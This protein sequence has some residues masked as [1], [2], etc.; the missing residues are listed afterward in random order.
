LFDA[1]RFNFRS[2][3]KTA[4]DIGTIVHKRLADFL[5]TGKYDPPINPKAL[6]GYKKGVEWLKDHHC[7][8]EFIETMGYSRRYEF[9][10]TIDYVGYIEDHPCIL[11]FK[12]SKDIY[13]EYEWQIAAYEQIRYEMDGTRRDGWVLRVGKEDGDFED[14]HIDQPTLSGHLNAFVGLVPIWHRLRDAD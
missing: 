8:V 4:T 6:V 12:T 9:A 11:D 5:E 3:S 7:R 2:V 14:R 1:A 13:V 10:S